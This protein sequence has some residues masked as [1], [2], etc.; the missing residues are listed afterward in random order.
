VVARTLAPSGRC[1]S[2]QRD[3]RGWVLLEAGPPNADHTVLLLPG[4][5]CTAAFF[6]DVMAEGKLSEA[7][8]RLLATTLQGFGGTSP[9]SDLSMESYAKLASK[10]AADLA[11]D[12]VVGH[13]VGANV[14]IEMAAAGGFSGPLALLAPSFSRKD[15]SMFPRVLDRLGIVFGHLPFAAM[16]RIIGAAMKSGLPEGRRD[17]LIAEM[18]KNDPASFACNSASISRTWTVTVRSCHDYATRA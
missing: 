6:E 5:L 11:C 4:A 7:S 1:G 12:A 13:S 18:K 9:P 16:L 8:I 3:D 14:A 17:A 15:E 2:G 10:L